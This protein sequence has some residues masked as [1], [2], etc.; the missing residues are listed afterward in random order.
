MFTGLFWICVLSRVKWKACAV[1]I[2]TQCSNV[3]CQDLISDGWRFSELRLTCRQNHSVA[4][5]K[6]EIWN[7]IEYRMIV[8][9]WNPRRPFSGNK[10]GKLT[11]LN[12]FCA[13]NPQATPWQ[14]WNPEGLLGLTYTNAYGHARTHTHKPR[15]SNVIC[16]HYKRK[17]SLSLALSLSRSLLF[18][19]ER[20]NS[21]IMQRKSLT[22]SLWLIG[23]LGSR[24]ASG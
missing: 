13:H 15:D 16:K 21:Y 1:A 14:Y 9:I 6:S 2:A 5:D 22:T 24:G 23:R 20:Q 7:W 17:H 19:E 8:E 18:S 3:P 11:S 4:A 10:T 12:T